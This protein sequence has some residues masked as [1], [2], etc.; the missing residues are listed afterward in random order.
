MIQWG[1]EV[2]YASGGNGQTKTHMGSGANSTAGF[3]KA[4]YQ[5]NVQVVSLDN[6]FHD[7]TDLQVLSELLRVRVIG[8]VFKWSK[9]L[10]I[11]EVGD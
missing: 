11:G 1:G 8:T 5:R 9:L 7:V 10:M 4:A 3:G 6:N 2:F